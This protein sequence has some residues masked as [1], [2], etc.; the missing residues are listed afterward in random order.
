MWDTIPQELYLRI[1]H[2]I[3][4]PK[5][6]KQCR[7]VCKYWNHPDLK[8]I[9]Q[10]SHIVV[11]NKD[12]VSLLHEF[13]KKHPTKGRF[14]RQII[15]GD[16]FDWNRTFL[17][18]MDLVFT[19]HLEIFKGMLINNEDYF[20][21]KIGNI[22]KASPNKTWNLKVI[23]ENQ[24][25][26]YLYFK[27]LLLLK[28]SLETIT[29]NF[30]NYDRDSP[31]D[32]G[33]IA[34]HMNQFTKLK[35][36]SLM[37]SFTIKELGDILQA[38]SHLKEL[39]LEAKDLDFFHFNR[40][41]SDYADLKRMASLRTLKIGRYAPASVVEYLICIYPNVETVEIDGRWYYPQFNEAIFTILK[42]IKKVPKYKFK[43]MLDEDSTTLDS[44]V[45]SI[46]AVRSDVSVE[47]F[48][49]AV[50]AEEIIVTSNL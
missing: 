29:L 39:Y 13:M 28:D 36:L 37:G 47:H 7:L 6:I 3:N 19:P 27:T 40:F 46:K 12:S 38:C 45:N 44:I 14:V 18:L 9:Q 42:T 33:R 32:K 16:V 8:Y 22:I 17:N 5:Q 4:E 41:S 50:D 21:Y 24:H 30:Y 48:I 2:Y 1:I 26:S 43:Y 15:L 11:N 20:Y 10:L 49:N 31:P 25:F 34:R 35:K 23:L